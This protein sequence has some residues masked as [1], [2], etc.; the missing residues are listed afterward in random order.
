MKCY[1]DKLKIGN[2]FYLDINIELAIFF[3][4]RTATITS[5]LF[6]IDKRKEQKKKKKEITPNVIFR[7]N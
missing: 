2:N 1:Q 3:H 4:N 5:H 7:L 6:P